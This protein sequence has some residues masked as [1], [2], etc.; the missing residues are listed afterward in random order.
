MFDLALRQGE[1]DADEDRRRRRCGESDNDERADEQA[2]PEYAG[3]EKT[4]QSGH[5]C[6]LLSSIDL[7]QRENDLHA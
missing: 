5:S 2:A 7:G 1:G 6:A 3:I 4:F